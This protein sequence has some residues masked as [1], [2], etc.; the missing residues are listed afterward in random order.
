VASH[1]DGGWEHCPRRVNSSECQVVEE[2]P[3]WLVQEPNTPETMFPDL[4][5]AVEGLP[6][7]EFLPAN[8][9]LDHYHSLA[10]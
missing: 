2:S 7:A 1:L 4:S 10:G 5:G 8:S 9:R 3:V 6:S